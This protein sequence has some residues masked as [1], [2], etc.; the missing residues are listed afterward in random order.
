[1]TFAVTSVRELSDSAA[2]ARHIVG[3]ALADGPIG[4][5]GLELEAHCIDLAEPRRRPDW[6]RLRAVIDALPALPGRA[7]VTVEPGGAVELSGPPADGPSAAIT[8]LLTDHAAVRAAFA[9]ASERFNAACIVSRG[10]GS[11]PSNAPRSS[12]FTTSAVASR[13]IGYPCIV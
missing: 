13:L 9:R 6:A 5:V 10:F 3:T 1:M 8:A 7:T 4:R 2:A 12:S 11:V